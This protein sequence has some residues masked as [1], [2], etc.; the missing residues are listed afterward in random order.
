MPLRKSSRTRKSR[1]KPNRTNK[2]PRSSLSAQVHRGGVYINDLTPLLR[3]KFDVKTNGK[4]VYSFRCPVN[5]LPNIT[6]STSDVAASFF[7]SLNNTANSNSYAALFDQYRIDGIEVTFNP[8]WTNN[9]DSVTT[10]VFPRLYVA[11]DYDDS[12]S[13]TQI[14]DITQYDSCVQVAPGRSI[15]RYF[16][17]NQRAGTVDTTSGATTGAQSIYRGW[18]DMAIQST[19]HYGIKVILESGVAGQTQLQTYTVDATLALSFRSVR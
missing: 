10:S 14:S 3:S 7:F 15:T 12:S 6:Q 19:P 13:L 5:G 16:V 8:R 18:L 4:R 2:T 17:P 11:I 9:V 1:P